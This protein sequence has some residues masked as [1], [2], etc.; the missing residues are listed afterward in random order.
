MNIEYL[1]QAHMSSWLR[2]LELSFETTFKRLVNNVCHIEQVGIVQNFVGWVVEQRV[3]K[4]ENKPQVLQ[5]LRHHKRPGFGLVL[6]DANELE[7]VEIEET[8]QQVLFVDGFDV[9]LLKFRRLNDSQERLGGGEVFAN[10]IV[11]DQLLVG[12]MN[13][14]LL[15]LVINDVD[16]VDTYHVRFDKRLDHFGKNAHMFVVHD[17]VVRG[18]A[19]DRP[20]LHQFVQDIG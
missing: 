1:R 14:L 10:K 8:R 13:Q 4:T 11:I 3:K 16:G 7:I 15:N 17:F 18:G 6:E 20:T 9:L 2:S 5:S 12:D 19:I